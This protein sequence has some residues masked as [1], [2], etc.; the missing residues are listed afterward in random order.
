MITCRFISTLV[1]S[2]SVEW[3][4]GDLTQGTST[5]VRPAVISQSTRDRDDFLVHSINCEFQSGTTAVRVLVPEPR[6]PRARYPVVYVLP[7]EAGRE[8]LHGDGLREVR[9]H[10][11]QNELKAV[12]VSPTFS[13]SPW[14]VDHPT[15]PDI[16]Q[17][18]YLLRVIIPFIDSHYPVRADAHSR[19]LLGFS[20]SGWGAASLLLRHPDVFGKAAIWDA[21]LMQTAPEFDDMVAVFGTR[22]NFERYRLDDLFE[23]RAHAVRGTERLALFGTCFFDEHH[24][25]AHALLDQ[26]TVAHRYEDETEPYHT[27]ESGWLPAAARWLVNGDDGRT[28]PSI[29][30]GGVKRLTLGRIVRF[31]AANRARAVVSAIGVILVASIAGIALIRSPGGGVLG[32]RNRVPGVRNDLEADPGALDALSLERG[33]V[34]SLCDLKPPQGLEP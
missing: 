26:L 13:H 33:P 25:A 12:F 9:R 8:Q 3:I 7:C 19:L 16:R 10:N 21:P 23:R 14:Y 32:S 34:C 24:Q 29:G 22:D 11:L 6:D 1:L 4:G 31:V 15:A 28:S 2:V 27:W 30:A 18:S 5:P 17:E 20:K